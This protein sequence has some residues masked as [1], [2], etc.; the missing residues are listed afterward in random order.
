M[1]QSKH[2]HTV[3]RST[4]P[5]RRKSLEVLT[6]P[7]LLEA[8]LIQTQS[9]CCSHTT[10]GERLRRRFSVVN[11]AKG[12]CLAFLV[13]TL[14]SK[15]EDSVRV[16]RPLVFSL[17]LCNDNDVYAVVSVRCAL[18]HGLMCASTHDTHTCID[19]RSAADCPLLLPHTVCVGHRRGGV[20]HG[21]LEARC[22]HACQ[23]QGRGPCALAH[24]RPSPTR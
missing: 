19:P 12:A 21:T 20:A 6:A 13:H 17:A 24:V 23:G 8:Y 5:A 10:D 15:E 2:A 9:K 3:L 4:P 1:R 14:R 7:Q 11:P 16:C 18:G 22:R